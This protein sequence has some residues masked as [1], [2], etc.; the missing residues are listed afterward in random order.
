MDIT[1]TPPRVELAVQP[2]QAETRLAAHAVTGRP[3]TANPVTAP[4]R[5]SHP[6]P[7]KGLGIPPLDM[8]QVGDNDDIP[9]PPE[10]PRQ[11]VAMVR[12][13]PPAGDARP[14]APEAAPDR[15]DNRADPSPRPYASAV[16]EPENPT[17]D[18]RR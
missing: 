1:T 6:A 14:D 2:T 9:L 7:I 5:P 16:A 18:I 17:V 11:S 3:E 15:S 10:P 13:D 12:V 4:D 8:Y